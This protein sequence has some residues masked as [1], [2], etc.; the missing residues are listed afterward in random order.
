MRTSRWGR[1]RQSRISTT[2][3]GVGKPAAFDL[4]EHRII[5]RRGGSY[6]S[7][8]WASLHQGSQLD[9]ALGEQRQD[10]EQ[11]RVA[12]PE[13]GLEERRPTKTLLSSLHQTAGRSRGGNWSESTT[14]QI[15][16]GNI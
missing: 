9:T 6:E 2:R 11:K 13:Y 4:L 12:S 10:Q 14:P 8:G 3:T 5:D 7:D 15:G 1:G 16:R